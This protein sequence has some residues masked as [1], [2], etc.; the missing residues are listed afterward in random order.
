MRSAPARSVMMR[1]SSLRSHTAHRPQRGRPG[2]P[3]GSG[4][5]AGIEYVPYTAI[6]RCFGSS[7]PTPTSSS[8]ALHGRLA[9]VRVTAPQRRVQLRAE[10]QVGMRKHEEL[11]APTVATLRARSQQVATERLETALAE[12]ARLGDAFARATGTSTEQS[13]HMRLAAASLQVS[14]CHR[15]V[16]MFERDD[17]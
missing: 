7:A 14:V 4:S 11:A 10:R 17:E 12:Q 6:C 5:G 2:S 9:P 16:K 8:A 1:D 13:S 3:P 15:A